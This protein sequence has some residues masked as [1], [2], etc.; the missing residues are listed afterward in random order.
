I[1]GAGFTGVSEGSLGTWQE[2]ASNHPIFTLRRD[3]NGAEIYA[4]TTWWTPSGAFVA[5]P[6][7]MSAGWWWASVVVGGL[8]SEAQPMRIASPALLDAGIPDA[9]IIDAGALDGGL[10]ADGGDL[11]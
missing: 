1:A 2:A 4:E 9:G 10:R 11:D 7:K 3:G 6:P 8:P 5:L